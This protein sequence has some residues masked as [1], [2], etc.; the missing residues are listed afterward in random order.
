MWSVQ[1][2]D[3]KHH[4]MVP[5]NL[6]QTLGPFDKLM[7]DPER[8]FI[9]HNAKFDL[10]WLWKY[11]YDVAEY[12]DTQVAEKILVAG[13]FK[14]AGLADLLRRRYQRDLNKTTRKDF[15]DGTFTA[16]H[17]KDPLGAWTEELV[18]YA[19]E[20]VIDL[21]RLMKDQLREIRREGLWPVLELELPL[22]RYNAKKETRGI[23]IDGPACLDFQ[24][25]MKTRSD[26]AKQQV[27]SELQP[28][29]EK[30]W[31]PSY[32]R[33]LHLYDSWEQPYLIAKTRGTKKYFTEQRWPK[34]K[35]ETP[36]KLSVADRERMAQEWVDQRIDQVKLLKE[37]KPFKDRPK[38]KPPLN[39]G[40]SGPLLESLRLYGVD[41][42]DTRKETLESNR[43]LAPI[44]ADILEY[45]KYVKLSQFGAL[46]GKICTACG[47]IHATVNQNGTATGRES[48]KEPN[49]QQI[50]ARTDEG[51][52]FR[53]L[54]RPR[55]GY[56][57]VAADYA[58]IELV[59]LGVVA[60][61]KTLI[62]VTNEG[63]DVHCFTMSRIMECDYDTL[64][65]AKDKQ[66]YSHDELK[67][68][69]RRF[70]KRFDL[71][72]LTKISW[73]HDDL[74]K[75][76]K[77]CRDYNKTISYGT[78]YGLSPFGMSKKFHCA[79]E[80]AEE[81]I[82]GWFDIYPNVRRFVEATG[83]KGLEEGAAYTIMGRRRLFRKPRRKNDDELIKEI[84]RRL[85]GEGRLLESL[86]EEEEV[87]LL[88]AARKQDWKDYQIQSKA[89]KREAGNMP[90][91]GTSADITKT[92][93][94]YV[95]EA[96]E[97]EGFPED[98]GLVLTVHDELVL[99]VH[100]SR[101]EKAAGILQT[102]MR[103]AAH[104]HLGCDIRIVVEPSINDYWS[105]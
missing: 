99:E 2:S 4:V 62:E 74:V 101:A 46:Y 69:R 73:G 40:S 15:Y 41:L 44:I 49:L 27:T 51:K 21:V 34:V 103:S 50:P 80:A 35:A 104:E 72:E 43:N 82:D 13:T 90:I 95:E 55:E 93:M 83:T 59:I 10:K 57:F 81:F 31:R 92:A 70:E 24:T 85:K 75:W 56:K 96:L 42:S 3:G 88:E 52:E 54:F 79:P 6:L 36:F 98:E 60:Q 86:T 33:N 102:N 18:L 76:V 22:V 87:E 20:D 77:Q 28:Y 89:I 78:V 16:A 26:E 11:G 48:W 19:M 7:R 65:A 30:F 14:S 1:Y 39:I 67:S 12:Y 91:Q 25:R 97:D 32:E 47:R 23:W 94:L 38:E 105:K 58:G 71:P 37:G 53:S 100:E 5:F 9:F 29:W 84:V 64:V 61:D 66:P 8:T 68:G 17:A 63:M 45:R